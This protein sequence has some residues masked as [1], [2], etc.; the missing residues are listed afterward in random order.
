MSQCQSV[1]LMSERNEAQRKATPQRS[2]IGSEQGHN[3]A[4]TA[5]VSRGRITGT[6]SSNIQDE[7]KSIAADRAQNSLAG[8]PD[9][10]LNEGHG[11]IY[12]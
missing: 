8:Q 6:T 5:V 10:T 7:S 9:P 3:A 11:D 2:S 4:M 12:G 1:G